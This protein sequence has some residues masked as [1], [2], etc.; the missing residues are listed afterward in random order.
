MLNKV[1]QTDLF[2]DY[3]AQWIA[4]YKQGAIRKVTMDKYLMTQRWIKKLAP[5]LRLCDVTRI[6]YQQILNDYNHWW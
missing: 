4:V 1:K 2:C 6:T 5:T 3:Y